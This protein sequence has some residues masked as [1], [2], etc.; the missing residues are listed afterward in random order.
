M[1]FSSQ[2]KQFHVDNEER[3]CRVE[4]VRLS[5]HSECLL[6]SHVLSQFWRN[7]GIH[8]RGN[9]PFSTIL[10]GILQCGIVVMGIIDA[11]VYACNYHRHSTDNLENFED[12]MERRTRLLTAIT[13]MCTKLSFSLDA[14]LTFPACWSA[15]AH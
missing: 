8:L 3:T 7:A 10:H 1:N 15:V 4:T 5:H 11:F 6:L 2:Q 14:R 9:L 12:C 13:P